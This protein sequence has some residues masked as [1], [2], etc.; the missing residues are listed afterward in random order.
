MS[1]NFFKKITEIKIPFLYQGNRLVIL[2]F[3][4]FF[5]S[6]YVT[7]YLQPHQVIEAQQKVSYFWI[8]I[9]HSMIP[10]FLFASLPFFIKK[11][12]KAK[13][14]DWN[15]FFEFFY[16][17]TLML[18][19]G[20]GNFLIRD[21]IYFHPN[22]WAWSIFKEEIGNNLSVGILVTFLVVSINIVLVLRQ[23]LKKA[24]EILQKVQALPAQ[25]T[26]KT[27]EKV[28][29]QNTLKSEKFS[30]DLS[31]FLFAKANGNYIDIYRLEEK[32]VKKMTKRL[33]L[34]NLKKNL[35]EYKHVVRTHKS[36]IVNLY[37]IE[38]VSGNTAGL[39]LKI[40]QHESFLIPV[41]RKNIPVFEAAYQEL[42][43]IS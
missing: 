19:V 34:S 36:Y 26:E 40:K 11:T 16:L 29:I 39:Q 10:A 17:T 2:T 5:I 37:M 9:W 43:T 3:L 31:H 18:L 12:Y 33:S 32:E 23:H 4:V 28:D 38:K 24:Q 15:I 41:S 20:I 6:F 42:D 27:D 30:L 22:N 13:N 14:S 25:K 8:C 21:F 1:I 35:D 7:Y